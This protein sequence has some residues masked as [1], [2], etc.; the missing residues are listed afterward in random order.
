MRSFGG[1]LRGPWWRYAG[2][3]E[4]ETRRCFVI[5]WGNIVKDPQD[6]YK[7]GHRSIRFVIKT[8]RGANR[9]E[10]HLVCVAYGD[11]ISAVIMRAMEKCDIVLCAGTWVEKLKVKTKKG[12][13]KMYECQ[14][15]FIVPL[16]L[17]RFLLDLYSLP[18][19][20]KSVADYRNAEAD[21]WESD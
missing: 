8:G 7:D 10:K 9:S 18:E 3:D 5:A 17:V 6:N 2:D 11:R 1:Y 13:K 4:T 12:I 14:V 21:P 16:D 19:L 20:Q 15:N